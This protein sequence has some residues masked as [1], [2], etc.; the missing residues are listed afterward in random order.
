M[1]FSQQ[2]GTMAKTIVVAGDVLVQEN[3]FI[4]GS[5]T[6]F[7]H[8]TIPNSTFRKSTKE[9]GG[10]R[11][12]CEPRWKRPEN[13]DATVSAPLLTAAAS[14]AAVMWTLFPP[15]QGEKCKDEDRV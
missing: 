15:V 4:E 1:A 14:R 6:Q 5:G 10:W 8:A 11:S 3:L 9:R 7:G 13:A 12:L 2:V